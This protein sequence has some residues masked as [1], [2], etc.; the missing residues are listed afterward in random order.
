VILV[1]TCGWIEW[2]TNGQ[3]SEQYKPFFSQIDNMIVPTSV[4]FELYKWVLRV[5]NI[6]QALEAVAL[7]EQ[8]TVIPLSPPITLSA[9]DFST[10]YKLSFADSIIY[11]TAQFHKARLITS[12]DHFKGLTDV[13]YFEKRD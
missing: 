6:Q 7:T 10:E 2:L 8:A 1:D 3:L 11:A 4:Q 5:S 12:D 13:E 9:A